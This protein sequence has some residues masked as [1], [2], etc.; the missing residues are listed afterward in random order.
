MIF[1]LL[2]RIKN[3][4][5]AIRSHFHIYC[6]GCGGTRAVEALLRLHPL[7]SLYYNP[8]VILL[9]IAVICILIIKLLET[10]GGKKERK[11]YKA[12]IIVCVVFL[13]LWFAFFLVRNYLLVY[14]GIDM[15]GDFV[16]KN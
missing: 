11:Y 3:T 16:Q 1:E 13:S 14:Q 10:R 8:C 5:C 2:D 15:L 4:G 9:L 12:R 6:P 7:Q